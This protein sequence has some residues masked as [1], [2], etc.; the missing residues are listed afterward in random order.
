MVSPFHIFKVQS[1]DSR[2]WIEAAANLEH[3]KARAK[4]L[5]ASSPGEYVI[6][7]LTAEEIF[8]KS[9]PKRIMFQIGYGEKELNTRAELF[10]RFG[11]EV[12]SVADNEAAKH[13]LT[14]SHNID[15]FVVGYQA[16]DQTRKEI[17]DWL[18][19][20]FPKVKIVA[21]VPSTNQQLR[22]ADYNIVLDDWDEWLTL[23]A[24]TA[25]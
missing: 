4:A 12:I 16:P 23:L 20:N 13:A 8:I 19:E 1:D 5:A 21:L 10:R 2:R 9:H 3:A 25:C 11:H 7:N 6:T 15:V 18:K 14:S 22:R 17:V 24:A